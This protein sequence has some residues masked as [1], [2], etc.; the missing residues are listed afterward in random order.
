[1]F[2]LRDRLETALMAL[3][4]IGLHRGALEPAAAERLLIERAQTLPAAARSMVRRAVLHPARSLCPFMGGELLGDLRREWR[5]RLREK[6]D[7]A[8]FDA[9]VLAA[10]ALPLFLVREQMLD[11]LAPRKS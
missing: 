6:Y 9:G 4:D 8:V 7:G 11:S 3:V 10:G 1:M 2:V 5:D